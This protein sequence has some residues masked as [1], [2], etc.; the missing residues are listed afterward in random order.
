[1][2]ITTYQNKVVCSCPECKK[3]LGAASAVGFVFLWCKQ[4]KKEIIFNLVIEPDCLRV[5]AF[6]ENNKLNEET[7]NHTGDLIHV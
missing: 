4:C 5:T 6:I 3:S 2:P 7:V 1:M